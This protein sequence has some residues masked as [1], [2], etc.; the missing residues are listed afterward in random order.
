KE[1]RCPGGSG[2][3]RT[4]GWYP[5]ATGVNC[6]CSLQTHK[7]RPFCSGYSHVAIIL[8]LVGNDGGVIGGR[9]RPGPD[10][11]SRTEGKARR[12]S[13]KVRSRQGAEAPPGVV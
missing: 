5:L 8:S 11:S 2:C 13:A 10:D 9:K 7:T 1:T 6:R 3:P 12:R 4:W